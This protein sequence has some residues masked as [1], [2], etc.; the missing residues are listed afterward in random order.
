MMPTIRHQTSADHEAVRHVNRLAFGQDDKDDDE[1]VMS[2]LVPVSKRLFWAEVVSACGG[3][4]SA[5]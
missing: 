5:N 3:G 1:W 4:V 2:R